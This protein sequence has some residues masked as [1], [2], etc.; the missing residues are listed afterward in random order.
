MHATASDGLSK[1]TVGLRK[2]SLQIKDANY[3]ALT[4]YTIIASFQK[5]RS[6]KKSTS[7]FSH[8][9]PLMVAT[10]SFCPHHLPFSSF[11]TIISSLFLPIHSHCSSIPTVFSFQRLSLQP[12]HM[13]NVK[14]RIF[15]N[16]SHII[17]VFLS[18]LSK[19]CQKVN[20]FVDMGISFH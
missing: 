17:I 2:K 9:C 5:L 18:D 8:I 10:L 12:P 16:D 4:I 20:I 15:F 7:L 14:L 11:H 3:S 6:S 13:K 1:S 19:F